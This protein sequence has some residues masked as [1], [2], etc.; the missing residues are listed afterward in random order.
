M[1]TH[2]DSTV[3][4]QG[5]VLAALLCLS[6]VT[7]A[8]DTGRSSEHPI[9]FLTRDGC[10]NTRTMRTRLDEALER[11]NIT[12]DYPVIDAD[13]LPEA[14]RRGGYGTPTVLYDNRDLFGMP[15]PSAPN[16]APT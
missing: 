8:T 6:A 13:A 3:G 9:V 15:E 4:A 5:L 7:W 16:P 1:W 14:D 12:T 10:V 2:N 11:L